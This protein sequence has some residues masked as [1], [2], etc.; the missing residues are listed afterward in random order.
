MATCQNCGRET[1]REFCEDCAEYVGPPTAPATG[2]PAPPAVL[3]GPE[4]VRAPIR[5]SAAGDDY[6]ADDVRCLACGR[7]NPAARTFCRFCGLPLERVPA[8]PRNRRLSRWQALRHDVVR[9]FHRPSVTTKPIGTPHAASSALAVVDPAP[10]DASHPLRRK[11]FA[12]LIALTLLGLTAAAVA[13]RPR[14]AATLATLGQAAHRALTL[15]YEPVRPSAATGGAATGYPAGLAVDGISNTSW[16]ARGAPVLRVD[17]TEPVDLDRVGITQG[18]GEEPEAYARFARA[19][20]LALVFDDGTRA[21][22]ALTDAPGF[23]S[24]PV[25]ARRIRWVRLTVVATYPGTV[26]RNGV[27]LSELEFFR[28]V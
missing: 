17:F 10:A 19:A 9:A 18:A 15:R 24:A 26:P 8:P 14:V 22:V 4:A 21:T 20:R 27:A 7:S 5:R 28:L 12:A 1:A 11:A 2:A 25:H 3:P 16:V 13:A 6:R 23:Q